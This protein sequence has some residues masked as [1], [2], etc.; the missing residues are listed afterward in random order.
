M[1]HL[2]DNTS[3][4]EI[5]WYA[6]KTRYKSE[7]FVASA[8]KRKGIEVYVPL[9]K[10]TRRYTRKI[11]HYEVPLISCYIFVQMDLSQ[12]VLVLDTMHVVE[13]V[14][15]DSRITPVPQSEIDMLRHV[16]GEIHEIQA[17]PLGSLKEGEEVE[18][19]MGGL[20]GLRGRLISA[21]GKDEFIIELNSLGYE[22]R[23]TVD[24]RLLN[25]VGTPLGL[26][27]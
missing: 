18:V 3:A 22:L 12:R 19:I 23:M 15:F 9:L 27:S 6:V 25:K 4:N 20:T 21:Q 13:F 7:K 11:K 26:P 2:T 17:S 5:R 1:T 24:R 8:L 14:S 10:R 16:V